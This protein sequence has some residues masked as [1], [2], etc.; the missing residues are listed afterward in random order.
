MVYYIKGFRKVHKKNI[1]QQ[2]LLKQCDTSDFTCT[3][4]GQGEVGCFCKNVQE[5]VCLC[6]SQMALRELTRWKLT[7]S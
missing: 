1:G 4:T 3:L 7:Y 6:V 2:D 5:Y